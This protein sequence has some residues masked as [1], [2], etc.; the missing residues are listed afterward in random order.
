M[1]KII[2][3]IWVVSLI[4]IFLFLSDMTY[5]RDVF[6]TTISWCRSDNKSNRCLDDIWKPDRYWLYLLEKNQLMN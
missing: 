6:E 5:Q 2:W 4:I 1:K 3:V